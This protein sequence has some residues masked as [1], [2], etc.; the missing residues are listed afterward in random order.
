VVSGIYKSQSIPEPS[1]GSPRPYSPRVFMAKRSGYTGLLFFIVI[2][3]LPIVTI[4]SLRNRLSE[5]IFV[6]KAAIS[7]DIMPAAAQVGAGREGF[8]KEYEDPAP[9]TFRPYSPAVTENKG[10]TMIAPGLIAIENRKA[11]RRLRIPEAPVREVLS[12]PPLEQKI[13]SIPTVSKESESEVKFQQGSG[14]KDAYNLLMRSSPSIAGLV[15]SGNPSLRFVSWGAAQ[16][17]EDVYWVRLR[18][19]S[20]KTQGE[21]DYIWEVKLQTSEV[22][23]LSYNAKSVD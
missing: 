11:P 13:Q 6:L 5:R 7:G 9:T 10:Y 23:P 16:K 18:F 14:E 17:G 15:Q 22:I 8:P 21:V 3:G 2:V 12:E 1:A 4:P 20:E 19:Q